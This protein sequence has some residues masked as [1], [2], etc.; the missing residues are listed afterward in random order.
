MSATETFSNAPRVRSAFRPREIPRRRAVHSRVSSASRYPQLLAL[1]A[2]AALAVA[3]F[4]VPAHLPPAALSLAL[5][6][7]G[8]AAAGAA[9]FHRGVR[10]WVAQLDPRRIVALHLVRFVGVAFLALLA[11]GRL[12]AAF[13]WP[14]G[15]GDTLVALGAVALLCWPAH[16]GFGRALRIWNAV[17]LLDLAAV[18]AIA[19]RLSLAQPGELAAFHTFPLS[20][21]PL[22]V[23][24]LLIASHVALF[25]H[26]RRLAPAGAFAP[27]EA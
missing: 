18:V 1:W 4:G 25:E 13:A 27:Q 5:A 7:L 19:L 8:F 2:G 24:P 23:A 15:I 3:L 22:V 26:T 14:A 21:L 6:W 9:L 10:A 11:Q 17:G 20:L 12:P 16:R